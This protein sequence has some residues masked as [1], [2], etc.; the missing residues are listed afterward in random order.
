MSPIRQGAETRRRLFASIAAGAVLIAS[1]AAAEGRHAVRIAAGPLDTS[2]VLLA[3]QTREQLLYAPGL[4]AGRRAPAVNGNLTAEQAL[5]QLLNHADIAITRAGPTVLVLRARSL[6]TPASATEPAAG[7]APEVLGAHPFA[8]EAAGPAPPP[9]AQG[10]PIADARQVATTVEAVQVT[11]SHIR[12]ANAGASPML[13]LDHD[14]LDRSGRATLAETLDLLPQNFSGEDS[15]ESVNTRAAKLGT[16][17]NY[18]TGVNLRGLGDK[19][20]LVLLNGRRLGGSGLK[21]DFTDVSSIPTVAVDRVEILLDG[22]SAI[23]GSDAVAGVVNVILKRDLEGGEVRFRGGTST[24]GGASEA[25]TGVVFGHQWTGGGALIA[26]EGT[27][28][29]RLS[30]DDRDYTASADL[31]RFGGSDF[32]LT[33]AFP[34]NVVAVNPA[35]GV[36]GPFFGIPPGQNGTGLTPGA[37]LPGAINRTSPQ[38]GLD[39]LPDQRTQ[40]VF[41]TLHQDL[42]DR[43]QVS[44]EGRYGY[45]TAEAHSAASTTTF[46]VTRADPFFVSPNGAASNQIQY[47][48]IGELPSP[49]TRGTARSLNATAGARL[50]LFGDWEANGYLGL[51][52]E[53]DINLVAGLINT[54]ILAEALGNAADNP[55]TPYS[56]ATDGFFNPYTGV[57]ANPPAVTRAIGSGYSLSYERSQISTADLQFDGTLAQ[58]PGGPL[59]LAV[60]GNVRAETY[61]TSGTNFLSTPTAVPQLTIKGHRSVAAAFAEARLPVVGPDNALPAVQALELSAAVRYERYSDF[62]DTTNPKLGLLWRPVQGLTLRATYGR[63]FRAPSLEDVQLPQNFTVLNFPVGATRVQSL[64]LQGG[65]ADLKPETATSWTLGADLAP[66]WAPGLNLSANWFDIDFKNRIDRPVLQNLVNA[67]VDPRFVDF[68]RRIQP[69]SNAADLALITSLLNDPAAAAIRNLNPPATYR[70]IVDIRAVNTSALHVRGL[71]LQGSY[72]FDALAGRIDLRANVSRLFTYAQAL[73]PNSPSQDL[74]GLATFPA[75]LRGRASAGWARGPF[76][77]EAAVNYVGSLRDSTGARVKAQATLDLQARVAPRDGRLQGTALTLLVRNLFDTHPP[78]Y[79][80]P[81]GFA[82]DPANAEPIGRYVAVQL[83]HRW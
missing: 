82:Y 53:T 47:D 44:A 10:R 46:T 69:D 20:T 54:A 36:S 41:A 2:L 72:G 61:L 9:T 3:T 28:R 73:T 50:Q 18:A 39:I 51:A 42:T 74:A 60:G 29:G 4:V 48:F 31:R 83:T 63:S 70:A 38:A 19:A 81:F 45:R 49:T 65:N 1:A 43:L 58:L 33:N 32:R 25:Q 78:F 30:A 76:G 8:G 40:T 15:E 24:E 77:V 37:F 64:A 22:A 79:N 66:A 27:L 23:Y 75:K 57:R 34:G 62:G 13:V 55:L 35:T 80:N 5:A 68:V 17:F 6:A 52:R 12:G 71:D 59:R 14:A 56:P 21:A 7:G 16:N 11:G 26:Y 67:L